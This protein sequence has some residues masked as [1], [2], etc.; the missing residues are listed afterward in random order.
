MTIASDWRQAYLA[1]KRARIV[2]SAPTPATADRVEELE[3]LL[4]A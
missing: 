2:K 3:E 4:A 1:R